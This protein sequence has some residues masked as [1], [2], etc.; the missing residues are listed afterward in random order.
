[1]APILGLQ[2]M[3]PAETQSGRCLHRPREEQRSG[4]YC[5]QHCAEHPRN[6][7]AVVDIGRFLSD[8]QI[9]TFLQPQLLWNKDLVVDVK[10]KTPRGFRLWEVRLLARTCGGR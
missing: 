10:A 1:V 2:A 8:Q 6:R 7:L 9:P 5:I 3:I 4:L